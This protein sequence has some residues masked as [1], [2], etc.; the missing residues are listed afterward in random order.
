VVDSTTEAEYVA[1]LVA[2]KEEVWIKKFITELDVIPSI[3]NPVDHYCDNNKAI[4]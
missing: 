1:V 2:A 4:A 3:M